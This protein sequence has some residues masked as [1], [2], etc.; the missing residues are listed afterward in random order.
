MIF[1]R[2]PTPLK[3]S[4]PNTK[5]ILKNVK[6]TTLDETLQSHCVAPYQRL[7]P[8]THDC[9]WYDKTSI[10]ASSGISAASLNRAVRALYSA[11]VR[12]YCVFAASSYHEV[13]ETKEVDLTTLI[14][15]RFAE[16]SWDIESLSL[17]QKPEL[18][19][20]IHNNLIAKGLASGPLKYTDLLSIDQH[21]YFGTTS[22][23]INAILLLTE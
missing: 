6:S 15:P 14:D 20:F 8:T 10:T 4:Q 3:S 21:H 16:L 1:T 2:I 5:S 22:I 9:R 18:V 12:A 19:K 17:Y 11:K 13:T 7:S 23:Q